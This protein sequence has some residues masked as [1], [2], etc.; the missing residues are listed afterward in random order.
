MLGYVLSCKDAMSIEESLADA[1]GNF[2]GGLSR[3]MLAEDTPQVCQSVGTCP[4]CGR[5]VHLCD[6]LLPQHL[7]NYGEDCEEG[8][9]VAPLLNFEYEE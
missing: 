9:H 1:Y 4:I 6:G 5:T 2:V 7:N 3:R 8:D